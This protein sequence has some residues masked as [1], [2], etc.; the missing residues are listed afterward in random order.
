[1]TVKNEETQTIF[2]FEFKLDRSIGGGSWSTNLLVNQKDLID[3]TIS[4]DSGDGE[5][6]KT[7]ICIY[8]QKSNDYE[9]QCTLYNGCE[10][11]TISNAFENYNVPI[12]Q[13]EL[14]ELTDRVKIL[15]KKTFPN[16][17]AKEHYFGH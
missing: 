9:Y 15:V 1:M 7:Y 4:H 13:K 8:L 17:C 6:W 12:T 11:E 3:L 5:G 16:T 2:N 10:K 14:N